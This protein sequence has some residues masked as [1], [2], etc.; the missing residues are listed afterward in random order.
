MNENGEAKLIF[1]QE[2]LFE[3]TFGGFD[4]KTEAKYNESNDVN[5]SMLRRL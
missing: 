3:E 1:D 2:M 4:F 5:D